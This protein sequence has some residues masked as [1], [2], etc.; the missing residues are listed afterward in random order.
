MGHMA[1]VSKDE[2]KGTGRAARLQLHDE[3][4]NFSLLE[5]TIFFGKPIIDFHLIFL[6]SQDVKTKSILSAHRIFHF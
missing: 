4:L 1:R 6:H 2:V 3:S 5:T